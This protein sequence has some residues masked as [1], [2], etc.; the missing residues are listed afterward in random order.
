MTGVLA[1]LRKRFVLLLPLRL[2]LRLKLI[3]RPLFT[4]LRR[5]LDDAAADVPAA[6][7][8]AATEEDDKDDNSDFLRLLLS[9]DADDE[10]EDDAKDEIEASEFLR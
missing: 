6:E 5:G 10:E 8:A 9:F 1:L 3:S 7:D 4:R 2:L